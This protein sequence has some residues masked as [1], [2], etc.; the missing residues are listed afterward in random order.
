MPPKLGLNLKK[1]LLLAFSAI[2]LL[3]FLTGISGHFSTKQITSNLQTLYDD[4]FDHIIELS[5]MIREMAQVRALAYQLAITDQATEQNRLQEDIEH[6]IQR[7]KVLI[8]LCDD[9]CV[10]TGNLAAFE[11]VQQGWLAFHRS[12]KPFL[13]KPEANISS[14]LSQTLR[15]LER[16]YE[17]LD[18]A[19]W[20]MAMGQDRLGRELYHDSMAAAD[21]A[22]FISALLL[23]VSV[24]SSAGLAVLMSNHLAKPIRQLVKRLQLMGQ[25]DLSQPLAT[26]LQQRG[27]EIGLLAT[28]IETTRQDLSRLVNNLLQVT[29]QLTNSTQTLQK[30]CDENATQVQQQREETDQVAA[31]MEQMA[32]SAS[33]VATSAARTS[34]EAHATEQVVEQGQTQMT[35]LDTSIHALNHAIDTANQSI[36]RVSDNAVSIESAL[37]VINE[38]AEQTNLLALNAAIESARAGEA[39]RGFAVV[40]DEVRSLSQRTQESTRTIEEVIRDL[41]ASVS[42]S[43]KT[44]TSGQ[45]QA[46]EVIQ[47]TDTAR[48]RLGK[49]SNSMTLLDEASALIASATQQQSSATLQVGQSVTNIR[50]ITEQSQV[51]AEQIKQTSLQ[52]TQLS[53]TL[54]QDASHFKL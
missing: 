40:A 13:S 21:R 53:Q 25:G 36:G 3:V 14:E 30:I 9:H 49:I 44:M 50:E 10:R 20:Q 5:E 35:H 42:E 37:Q 54:K 22:A 24:I 12:L 32:L 16:D 34:S 7:I 6:G 8:E 41:Q 19:A 45:Q 26:N 28:G 31:A 48:T 39:G 15:T 52:L 2:T 18:K 51:I 29:A 47:Q 1:K 23:L 33:E 46:Q 11:P 27:D 17:I 38:I 43:V 4:R